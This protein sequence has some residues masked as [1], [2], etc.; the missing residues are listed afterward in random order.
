MYVSGVDAIRG[1]DEISG[2]F[3]GTFQNRPDIVDI[4]NTIL[5]IKSRKTIQ[6][7]TDSPFKWT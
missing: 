6:T 2:V 3:I 5:S 1:L 4:R 7:L